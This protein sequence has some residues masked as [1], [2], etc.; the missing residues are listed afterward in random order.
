MKHSAPLAAVLL[1]SLALSACSGDGDSLK[2]PKLFCPQ[3]A[4]LTPTA[5]LT[6]FLPSSNDVTA[7][8]T[9]AQITGVA[10]A[11]SL[12]KEKQ[13]VK[14]TFKAGFTATNGPANKSNTLNL[15]YFVAIVEGE[16][17]IAKTPYSIP[18]SFDGNASSASAESNNLTV[19]LPNIPRNQGVQVLVGFQLTPEQQ[20]YATDH[21]GL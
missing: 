15:P 14:V 12:E 8:I 21:P 10:G 1:A 9:S 11:C 20:A 4:V 17:I 16:T 7:E 5:R 2:G 13:A 3:V 18:I 6:A 19:E